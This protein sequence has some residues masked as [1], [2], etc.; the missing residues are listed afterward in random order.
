[1][2][3][4][5]SA[6]SSAFML[7]FLAGAVPASAAPGEAPTN[8]PVTVAT[9]AVDLVRASG[10]PEAGW[11]GET[12]RLMVRSGIENPGSPLTGGAA[13]SL[14]RSMGLEAFSATPEGF[15]SHKRA[16]AFV[17]QAEGLLLPTAPVAFDSV[18]MTP[19]PGP[20][21]LDDCIAASR[22]HG[23]CV[24]CCKDLGIAA[25]ACTRFCVSFTGNPSASEPIP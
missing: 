23:V 24:N 2:P 12:D 20:G 6:I 19:T 3:S 4:A 5:K 22:N 1:M 17:R 9:F 16:V 15:V 14:L 8:R 21:S 25:N 13:A 10:V 18:S 7:A 11:K